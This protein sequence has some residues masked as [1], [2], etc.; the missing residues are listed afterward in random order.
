LN[1]PEGPALEALRELA[2]RARGALVFERG[3]AVRLVALGGAERRTARF[4]SPE[5]ALATLEAGRVKWVAMPLP[6]YAASLAGGLKRKLD[7]MRDN[8]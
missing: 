3:G 7:S 6:E 5:A 8:H 1:L 2:R 4:P